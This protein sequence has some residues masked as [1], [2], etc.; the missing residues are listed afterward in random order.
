MKKLIFVT[1]MMFC[2]IQGAIAQDAAVSENRFY[3][4]SD[5]SGG[6]KSHIS[7]YAMPK[8]SASVAQNVR[9]NETYGDLV[10]REKMVQLSACRASAVKSLHRYYKSDATSYLI[11]TSSTYLDSINTTTGACTE[12]RS[13][14]SDSKRWQWVTYK[15]IAI[16]TNGTDRAQ[17]WD[18]ASTT[19]ANTDGARTAGDLTADLGAPFAELNTG[20]DLDASSWYQYR[21]AFYDGTTY[22]YSLARSN[23]IVTG[24]A[25]RNIRLTDIPIGPTGTTAR[26]IYRTEGKASRAA[27]IADT[28]FYRVATISDNST[29]TY[30][31]AVTD[32]TLLGDS[33]P[34]WATV[35]AGINVTPPYAKHI[36]INKERIYMA[37]DPSGTIAGRSTIY[38]SD[39]LNP[40][41]FN[42]A[43]DYELIR[44][45]DGDQ[46]TA[47]KNL[48]STSIAIAKEGTWNYLYNDSESTG[49]W[50]VSAPVSYI[51]VIAPYS[52][53]NTQSGIVYISR[54]GLY[55]FNGVNSKLVSDVVTDKVRDIL[56]TS[57]DDVVA[58]FHDNQYLMA[59]TSASTGAGENDRVLVLDFVRNAYA[60]DTKQIDSWATFYGTGD[61]GTLYSGSSSTDGKVYAHSGSFS[62]LVYRYFSQ[63]DA[64]TTS[65][66]Y[67]GG[68]ENEPYLS[69][70]WD[71]NW[72]VAPGVWSGQGSS[73]WLVSSNSGTWTSPAVNVNAVSYD[74]LYWNEDLGSAGNVTWAVRSAATEG[75]ISGASW[76]SEFS[77]PSGS[78]I[79]ALTANDWVQ[80]RATLSTSSYTETP[81][82]YLEDSFVAKM[83]YRQEGSTGESSVLSV[84]QSGFSDMGSGEN[85]SRIREVQVYYEGTEGTLSFGLENDAGTT[86]SFDIDLALDPSAST[87]DDYFGNSTEKI[88]RW[89]P[90]MTSVPIGRKWRF[91]INETGTTQWSVKRIAVRFDTNAY[92]SFR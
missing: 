27:V 59:Y 45:D 89:F 81:L 25:V 79:S 9:F 44:P 47:I 46:I 56:D 49:D 21:V 43:T 80:L 2:A 55:T 61:Y 22:K 37:N 11:Q 68:T 13:G 26:V 88:Y 69:L 48:N 90:A 20:S 4:I 53:V 73:T 42:T 58:V 67:I 65:A 87:S 39:V 74:K 72:A 28:S 12:L 7:A 23:P 78:D 85:P 62:S 29:R 1:F 3:E 52:A 33:A 71:V 8:G 60:E 5:F 19:T 91:N 86:H 31:D 17:K 63:F 76:S 38:W 66:V 54:H 83:T 82:V 57:S 24:A 92:V 16:G 10:K 75:G 34:T 32:V 36:L 14:M 40:D 15:D 18:G 6:L 70:G 35:S 51:G 77:T 41:Y 84:W 50:V 64:G 30:D